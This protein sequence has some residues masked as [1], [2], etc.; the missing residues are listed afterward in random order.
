MNS[1]AREQLCRGDASHAWISREIRCIQR[2]QLDN[3]GG[4]H[5]GDNSRVVGRFARNLM[6]LGKF[7]PSPRNVRRLFDQL[8]EF[9][10]LIQIVR[11]LIRR[12]F[13][14]IAR[15]RPGGDGPVLDHDLGADRQFKPPVHRGCK[16]CLAAGMFRMGFI[17]H[18]HQDVRIDED[19]IRS[20]WI[21]SRRSDSSEIE[22][23]VTGLERKRR[24]ASRRSSSVPGFR[25]WS[26]MTTS[27]DSDW[28]AGRFS[29]SS[30]TMT[31]PS[32][33]AWME[34]RMAK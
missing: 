30:G 27:T 19:Q 10:E 7:H 28:P 13:Q 17:A 15:F 20:S 24:S 29:G 5:Q 4:F 31:L 11:H 34:R 23:S 3:S 14:A 6:T 16:D 26:G 32:K 33:C 8:D 1:P 2:K 21:A 12:Q 9:Q 22:A 25:G 18:T